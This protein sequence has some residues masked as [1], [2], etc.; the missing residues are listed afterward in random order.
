M[1][2]SRRKKLRAFLERER[3]GERGETN[4]VRGQEE[5]HQEG[6]QRNPRART[7]KERGRGLAEDSVSVRNSGKYER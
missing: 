2:T 3:E 5:A 7:Q 1:M 6:H 4:R